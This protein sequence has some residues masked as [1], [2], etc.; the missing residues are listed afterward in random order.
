MPPANEPVLLRRL[1]PLLEPHVE[2]RVTGGGIAREQSAKMLGPL[3]IVPPVADVLRYIPTQNIFL[4]FFIK[5]NEITGGR[6]ARYSS[7]SLLGQPSLSS[8]SPRRVFLFLR[9]EQ[10]QD[11]ERWKRQKN[12]TRNNLHSM[13]L[14]CTLGE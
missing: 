13:L 4:I 5:I 14:E 10:K 9:F 8:T 7:H 6:V 2:T 12:T 3:F 1:L 11:E